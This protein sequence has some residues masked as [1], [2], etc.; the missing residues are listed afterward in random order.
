[1]KK[2]SPKTRE[3]K[4]ING[5]LFREIFHF[6][7]FIW[8]QNLFFSLEFLSTYAV[9]KI[10]QVFLKKIFSLSIFSFIFFRKKSFPF[11]WLVWIWNVE[12]FLCAKCICMYLCILFDTFQDVL[13]YLEYVQVVVLKLP[14]YE[15]FMPK[16]R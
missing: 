11:F 15:T 1:M 6:L 9:F 2:T 10:S 12:T 7:R 16:S 14:R 5:G 3:M 13:I 4:W 8:F